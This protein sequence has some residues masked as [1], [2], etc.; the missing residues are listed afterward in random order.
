V[1]D[2]WGDEVGRGCD[3]WVKGCDMD[4]IDDGV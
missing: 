4:A 3:R 1:V 2:Y